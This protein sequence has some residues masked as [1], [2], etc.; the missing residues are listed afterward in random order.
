MMIRN[1]T[2]INERQLDNRV[3]LIIC[4]PSLA[5]G[6]GV[7][8]LVKSCHPLEEN[9]GYAYLLLCKHFHTTCV[10]AKSQDQIVGFVSAYVKPE[11]G[12]TLFVWQIAVHRDWRKQGL[13][14]KMLQHLLRRPGLRAIRF[15]EATVTKSNI[16]SKK[17]FT[18]IAEAYGTK[19]KTGVEFSRELFDGVAHED[20]Y[21]YRIGPIVLS[22]NDDEF[23]DVRSDGIKSTAL[24]TFLPDRFFKSQR[25]AALGRK[26]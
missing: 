17:L 19:C 12:D 7:E 26:G 22:E 20:E 3:Q 10:V 16:A 21:L 1:L 11:Q 6:Q 15:L 8:N 5:D 4:E 18:S 24:H 25:R 2:L 13:G 9:S 14:L 23:G